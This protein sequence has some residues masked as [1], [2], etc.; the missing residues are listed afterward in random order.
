MSTQ[1]PELPPI[2]GAVSGEIIQATSVAIHGDVYYDLVIRTDP[3]LGASVRV[4]APMHVCARAPVVGDRVTA[5]L[6]M[7]QVT[8]LDFD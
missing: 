7:Q 2:A 1:S 3:V 6:L 4:R 5:R 8:G